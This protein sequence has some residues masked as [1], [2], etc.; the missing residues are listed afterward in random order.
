M[1]LATRR[2]LPLAF[3]FNLFLNVAFLVYS[4]TLRFPHFVGSGSYQL[5][6]P[7]TKPHAQPAWAGQ[8]IQQPL[9][10]VSFAMV[11]Y[12]E[13]SAKE[14]LLAL[15]SVLMHVSRP[16]EFHIICSPDAIPVLQNKLDLFSR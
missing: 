4:G 1:G 2:I 15:K 3:I 9:E 6:N 11:M 12:G 13:S 7:Q 5:H 14:G 10:P 8:S 16:A